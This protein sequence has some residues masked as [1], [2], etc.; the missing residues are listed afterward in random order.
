LTTEN[1][2]T[3][4]LRHAYW[5]V[6]NEEFR[7][8]FGQ[9][10]DV[11]SPLNPGTLM[12]SVLWDAGN[13]GYRRAQFR[14]ER[15]LAF[16]DVS[17]LTLQASANQTFL[18]DIIASARSEPSN[19][20]IIEMRTATTLGE[21]GPGGHP[22]TFGVWGHIG[23]EEHH[24]LVAPIEDELHRT[25]SVGSDFRWPLTDRLGFQAEFFTGENLGAFL[26]GI[27]Q[28]NDPLTFNNIRSTGGWCEVWYDW[29]P[30]LHSHAGYSLDDPNNHDLTAIGDKSYNQV[31]WGNI[32][33]D[34][35]KN[36]LAGLEVSSWKTLYVGQRPGESV[37][38]EFVM[39][40]GF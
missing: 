20:P 32:S 2:P 11:I 9:T 3:I 36:F 22:I 25:W 4:L 14:A 26:G 19:W 35:T 31:Y 1:R 33:Y 16:S 6:K 37:R 34:I 29:T 5:E 39:K 40:Y 17:L 21:R 24:R 38:T 28:G 15:Y 13:I 8:L 27:G 23:T 30:R 18:E 7:L 12:Y 10:W